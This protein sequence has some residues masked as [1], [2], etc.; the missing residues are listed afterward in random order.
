M[1]TPSANSTLLDTA[2][3]SPIAF[4]TFPFGNEH[5][6]VE[7]LIIESVV[8]GYY[9]Y[10]LKAVYDSSVFDK[11]AELER[12]FDAIAYLTPSPELHLFGDTDL[13]VESGSQHCFASMV[14]RSWK[15]KGGRVTNVSL[16]GDKYDDV[17]LKK[18]YIKKRSPKKKKEFLEILLR[19]LPGGYTRYRVRVM[20]K[21]LRDEEEVKNV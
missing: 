3:R 9:P 15:E 10:D 7:R 5:G 8:L 11:Q 16:L 20:L 17:L 12:V 18:E 13:E 21:R 14:M 1:Q 19:V 6:I 2:G 4:L